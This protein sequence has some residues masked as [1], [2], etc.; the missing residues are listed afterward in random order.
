LL[1]CLLCC[2]AV[3]CVVVL[4]VV[5]LLPAQHNHKKCFLSTSAF[6]HLELLPF[7]QINVTVQGHSRKQLSLPL[8]ALRCLPFLPHWNHLSKGTHGVLEEADLHMAVCVCNNEKSPSEAKPTSRLLEARSE[9]YCHFS[10]SPSGQAGES[11][12]V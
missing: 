8:L 1:C 11:L 7:T 2:C 6:P 12:K 3:C 9:F 5:L 10:S 4:F